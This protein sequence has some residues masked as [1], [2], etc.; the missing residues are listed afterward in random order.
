MP[1]EFKIKELLQDPDRCFD[2]ISKAMQEAKKSV[3][4]KKKNQ[5]KKL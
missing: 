5:I 1:V 4:Q 2:L 3:V